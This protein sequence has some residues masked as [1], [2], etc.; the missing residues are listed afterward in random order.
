MERSYFSPIISN[1]QNATLIGGENRKIRDS[2]ITFHFQMILESLDFPI[3]NLAV[4][5]F[6][7]GFVVTRRFWI[8]KLSIFKIPDLCYMIK[9]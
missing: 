8:S 1:P 2:I 9:Y 5:C 6:C 7:Y 3:Y 4:W